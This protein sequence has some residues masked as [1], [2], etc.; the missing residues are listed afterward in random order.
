[1]FDYHLHEVAG[2]INWLY[3]FNTW[4]FPSW[5]GSVSEIHGCEACWANW[6]QAFPADER[7]RASEAVNL[8]KEAQAMLDSMDTMFHAHAVVCLLDA[9]S[10][11]DDIIIWT[12]D[13]REVRLPLLR[14]QYGNECL[15][16]SDF[17]LPLTYGTRDTIGL[18]VASVDAGMEG[19]YGDDDYRHMICQTL[20][21]RLAEATAERVHED[22]R[23]RL[24]GYAPD[25]NLTVRQLF[26][27]EYQGKRPAVGY[28]SLPDMSL[29]F[30]LSDILGMQQIGVSLTESGAMVPH[31]STSGLMLAHPKARHFS[32]GRIG[33]DQLEDY[34]RRRGL[35]I[36]RARQFLTA[37]NR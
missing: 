19:S 1:M 13:G 23:K 11:G 2:Y 14:Q 22:V 31:A 12:D 35:S 26:S 20:S 4:G 5:Y 29:N 17:V 30:L 37:N 27:E 3:F 8:Y 34:A 28:P 10:D 18:F 6:L 33:Q 9:N 25:E 36:E 32:V 7:S 15:C 16:L 21:D 24:W